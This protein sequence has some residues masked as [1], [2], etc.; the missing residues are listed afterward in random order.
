M[1]RCIPISRKFIFAFGIVCSLCVL[2]GVYTV[3]TFRGIA[4]KS[5]EVSGKSLPSLILIGNIRNDVNVER[6]ETLEM[7]MCQTPSCTSR[8]SEKRQKAIAD[9][10][11]S[12]REIAPTIIAEEREHYE[13]FVA[14]IKQYQDAS[15]RGVGLLAAGKT[16]DALDLLSS[17]A[18]M[19]WLNDALNATDNG[20]Q[21]N[22]K[23][24]TG[25]AQGATQASI[26]AAWIN[27]GVTLLI[28]LLVRSNRDGADAR[29]GAAH[30]SVMS[31][32]ERVAQKDLTASV[33]VTGTDE[34]GRMAEALNRTVASM[35]AVLQSVA[36]GRGY[37]FRRHHG[38][39]HAVR[40]ERRQCAHASRARSTRSPR[41]RRR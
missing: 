10:Q 2:L 9:Y 16:G 41:R 37:A 5:A 1:L 8:H 28:M 23:L 19:G 3:A 30:W 24:G 39:Q 32:L 40:A 34:I 18:L 26:H 22:A 36:Q 27:M 29:D 17:D 12:L 11:E 4:Q 6:R 25:S 13:K 7:M 14:S 15:D 31:T 35:R 33:A 20:V 38:D 21:I